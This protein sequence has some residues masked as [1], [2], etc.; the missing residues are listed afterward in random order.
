VGLAETL[1]DLIKDEILFGK[2]QEE[3]SNSF[4]IKIKFRKQDSD[5]YKS[6]FSS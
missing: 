6:L 3:L 2:I 5:T 1:R 4:N